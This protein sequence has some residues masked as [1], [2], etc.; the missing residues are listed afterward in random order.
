MR[1]GGDAGAVAAGVI[2]SL[3]FIVGA[4]GAALVLWRWRKRRLDT[5]LLDTKF[6]DKEDQLR[7]EFKSDRSD[8][9]SKGDLYSSKI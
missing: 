9:H 5:Y 7:I 1:E 4:G 8:R 6:D 3:L 2:L